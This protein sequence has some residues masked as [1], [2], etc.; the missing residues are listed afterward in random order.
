MF[1]IFTI[2]TA[3]Y[4]EA[5]LLTL[6]S[7]LALD[8]LEGVYVYTDF[9]L[10]YPDDRVVF[11]QNIKRSDDWLYIVG[12]KAILLKDFIQR[13]PCMY[14]AFIDA[15]CYIKSDI[16]GVF[17]KDFDIAP[18]RMKVKGRAA[19]SGVWF[20]KLSDRLMKFAKEWASLQEKYRKQGMGVVKHVSSYSQR[21]FSDIL[22]RELAH[23]TYLF[24][25][26]LSADVYN[27]EDDYIDRWINRLKQHPAKIIHFKGRKWQDKAIVEKILSL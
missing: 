27:N 11:I 22:H 19:N 15:D 24:V 12:L 14:F 7:W 23:H 5:L 9:S 20:C 18:T 21:S 4:K 25:H 8:T 3:N 10:D 26:P 6:P 16:S 17:D 1:S 2:C 13:S